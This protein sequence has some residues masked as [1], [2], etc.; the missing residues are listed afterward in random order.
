MRVCLEHSNVGGERK[1]EFNAAWDARLHLGAH[2]TSI[3]TCEAA[4]SERVSVECW[5]LYYEQ[6]GGAEGHGHVAFRCAAPIKQWQTSCVAF[7][8]WH[9]TA[10]LW[11]HPP[12]LPHQRAASSPGSWRPFAAAQ[13]FL[14][15]PNAL[16]PARPAVCACGVFDVWFVAAFCSLSRADKLWRVG[17]PHLLQIETWFPQSPLSI[18]REIGQLPEV[19]T[20]VQQ[21]LVHLHHK[22]RAGDVAGNR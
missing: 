1:H 5:M 14:I 10:A 17:A 2:S 11:P 20:P 15:L 12:G 7:L 16:P 4:C 13:R 3:S 8:L 19:S 9:H 22:Q 6:Q 21:G 18:V